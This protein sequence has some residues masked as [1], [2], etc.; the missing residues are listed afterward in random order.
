[1]PEPSAREL[2]DR[3]GTLRARRAELRKASAALQLEAEIYVQLAEL[4]DSLLPDWLIPAGVQLWID[5]VADYRQSIEA[6]GAAVDWLDAV[7]L[8]VDAGKAI[9]VAADD[10]ADLA[11]Y[12]ERGAIPDPPPLVQQA[13]E[14][15]EQG[16][17][18]AEPLS[19][20]AVFL[21]GL[22][23]IGATAS[24]IAISYAVAES[25]KT[26]R[27][28][29]RANLITATQK[30]V[31]SGAFSEAFG[32]KILRT[33]ETW[34]SAEVEIEKAKAEQ[35]GLVTY[36]LIG[37]FTIGAISLLWRWQDRKRERKKR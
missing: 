37:G 29:I 30:A 26:R 4:V 19:T 22:G 10:S 3:I 36:L 15:P 34:T 1:M 24:I 33:I 11:L 9:Y 12:A 16:Q 25:T 17:L 14:D 28:T 6:I 35:P 5:Q 7:D 23:I 32:K 27:E 20:G 18:G 21:I 8:A 2:V 31:A 13:L